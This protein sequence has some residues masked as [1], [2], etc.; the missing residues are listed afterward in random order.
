MLPVYN[1]EE[2]IENAINSILNQSYKKFELIILDNNS[3]DQTAA[4]CKKFASNDTRIKYILDTKNRTANEAQTHLSSLISGEYCLLVGDDDQWD[5]EYIETLVKFLKFNKDTKMVYTRMSLFDVNN[6]VT[7]NNLPQTILLN[8][9][10]IF[11]NLFIYIVIRSCVPMVFGLFRSK[12]YMENGEW[13]IFDHTL[14]D[15][16]NLFIIKFLGKNK[17]HCIDKNMFFYRQKNRYFQ[18]PGSANLKWQSTKKNKFF[19]NKLEKII[20]EFNFLKEIFKVLK[21]T[22]ITYL[23]KS[24]LYCLAVLICIERS[25]FNI[26]KFIGSNIRKIYKF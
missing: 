8:D 13:R 21:K 20:H 14:T 1:G 12:E 3:K 17:V 23:E 10:S 9:N 5:K 25:F 24:C 22:K 11:K 19:L 26:S 7:Q 2:F 6:D 18:K 15:V 4:I 16:D